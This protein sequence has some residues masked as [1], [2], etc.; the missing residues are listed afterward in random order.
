MFTNVNPKLSIF[1]QLPMLIVNAINCIYLEQTSGELSDLQSSANR[2]SHRQSIDSNW[3]WMSCETAAASAM[4]STWFRPTNC[5]YSPS[6]RWCQTGRTY[7]S[8]TAA[9]ISNR[10]RG[11]CER[12]LSRTVSPERHRTD[13]VELSASTSSRFGRPSYTYWLLRRRNSRLYS[14]FLQCWLQFS[15]FA[16]RT[17]IKIEHGIMLHYWVACVTSSSVIFHPGSLMC[18]IILCIYHMWFG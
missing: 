12:D 14:E 9:H 7:A 17:V 1:Y 2:I 6:P 11:Q 15:E 10:R 13:W 18:F 16:N 8:A 5:T 4:P 3:R